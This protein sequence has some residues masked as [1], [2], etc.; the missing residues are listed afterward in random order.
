MSQD[1]K[2]KRKE[3]NRAYRAANAEKIAE[4]RREA[5]RR[6]YADDPEKYRAINRAK[7]AADPEMRQ[8]ASRRWKEA[9]CEELQAKRKIQ[10]LRRKR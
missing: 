7:Y 5:A 2:E 3:Y 6:R 4:Q 8:R 9:N 1:A 10:Y